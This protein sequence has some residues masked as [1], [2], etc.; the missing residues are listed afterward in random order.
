MTDSEQTIVD[1]IQ[2]SLAFIGKQYEHG[3]RR[4]WPDLVC[5]GTPFRPN[6]WFE[7]PC[8]AAER[9]SL[10]RACEAL[11]DAGLVT[12]VSTGL[13]TRTTHIRPTKALVTQILAG[14]ADDEAKAVVEGL[15]RTVWG[16]EMIRELVGS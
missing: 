6:Q 8:T 13:G 3:V 4:R 9:K 1:V 14:A 11:A 16:N 15:K 10:S 12:R 7:Q 2:D 5:Y